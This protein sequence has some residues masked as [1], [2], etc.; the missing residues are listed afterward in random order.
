MKTI[1]SKHF[2][3]RG[4][5]AITLWPFLFI[6]KEHYP[7]STRTFRHEAIHAEQQ[8]ETGIV[9][10]YLWYGLEYLVRRIHYGSHSK[11]YRSICFEAEAYANDVYPEYLKNRT[12]WSFL[13]YSKTI[14]YE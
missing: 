8:K 2:P 3:A 6:R 10:F 9:L 7:P 1:I 12:S 11:A 14:Y 13:K 5:T 4:Y